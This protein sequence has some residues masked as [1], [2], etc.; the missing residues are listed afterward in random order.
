MAVH[1]E[2]LAAA[3]RLGSE[4]GDWTFT[5]DEVVRALPH[6]NPGTVRTHVTSRCCENAPTNH[7]HKWGYFRRIARGRYKVLSVHRRGPGARAQTARVAE[8]RTSYGAEVSPVARQSIHGLVSRS[9]GYFVVECLEVAVV[10]QGRTLDEAIENLRDAVALH[11][12]GED[13]VALGLVPWPRLLI[14]YETSLGGAQT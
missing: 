1:D 10:T 13:L 5:P 7:P 12:E 14:T 4:R 6:L 3:R 8:A 2:V 11:L 9:D